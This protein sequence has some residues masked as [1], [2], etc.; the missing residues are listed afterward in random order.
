MNSATINLLPLGIKKFLNALLPLLGEEKIE[1]IV[2]ALGG[3][4]EFLDV[5]EREMGGWPPEVVG[6]FIEE[7]GVEFY[8]ELG[9]ALEALKELK[10]EG[11]VLRHKKTA[12][13]VAFLQ[14]RKGEEGERLI[15]FTKA[16]PYEDEV[17][18]IQEALGVDGETIVYIATPSL[19]PQILPHLKNLSAEPPPTKKEEEETGEVRLDTIDFTLAKSFPKHLAERAKAIPIGLNPDGSVRLLMANPHNL[20]AID[21]AR[22]FLKR[23][24]V[25]IG[26]PEQEVIR[27]IHAIWSDNLESFAIEGEEKEPSEGTLTEEEGPARL[28]LYNLLREAVF[29][30]ASDIHFDPESGRVAIRFRVDGVLGEFKTI[31]KSFY[32]SVLSVIKLMSGM[33]I[34]ERRIPQDG[35]LRYK[36]KATGIRV[37]ARVSTVAG[38]YGEKV[39]MRL[40]KRAEDIPELEELGFSKD[41]YEKF[42][43]IVQ[44]PY[45]MILVTGPTGSGKSFTNFSVLK[46]IATKDKNTLTVEDPVEYEIPGI[47]QV[48][49]NP[50][51]GVTFARVLRTFLRQDPDIIMVGEIRDSETAKIATEAALTG[52]LV[53]ATLHTNDAPQAVVRLE[54]MGV[55]RWNIGASLLGVLSQRLV[56]T[57]CPKCKR[58]VQDPALEKALEAEGLKHLAPEPEVYEAV[59]CDHCRGTGYKGRT[60][61]HELMVVTPRIRQAIYNGANASEIKKIAI[62]E[63]ML[64]LRMDGLLKAARGIT[65]L[66]EVLAKTVE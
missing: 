34:T 36:D 54:Q 20:L 6:T 40:L 66:E 49:V 17:F 26:A 31:G 5:L 52:H 2:Q 8:A 4:E 65:T 47:T 35:R 25:P 41:N 22:F 23:D 3:G 57:L 33:D 51:I 32:P 19:L 42:L 55:E 37:D 15:V 27:I 39:V 62:E 18:Q 46:R 63:G 61:I 48:P 10:E 24:V 43:A 50:Q 11:E 59:G 9:Q 53:L 30:G 38:V 13:S 44:K 28:F 7:A 29:N 64:T 12:H 1:R 16:F 14:R 58:K 45:G 60:A 21:D 56:R